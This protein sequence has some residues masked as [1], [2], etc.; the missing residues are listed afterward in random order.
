MSKE[1]AD[2]LK[3]AA[4]FKSS[5]HIAGPLFTVRRLFIKYAF[6]KNN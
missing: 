2:F 3:S 6:R 4:Q 1:S 5:S